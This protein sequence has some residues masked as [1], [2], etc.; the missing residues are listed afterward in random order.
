MGLFLLFASQWFDWSFL[1][2]PRWCLLISVYLLVTSLAQDAE[3]RRTT[4]SVP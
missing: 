3:G 1:V 4:S 2:L